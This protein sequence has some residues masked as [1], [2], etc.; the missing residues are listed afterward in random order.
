MDPLYVQCLIYTVLF[1]YTVPLLYIAVL[2]STLLYCGPLVKCCFCTMSLKYMAHFVQCSFC[3]MSYVYCRFYNTL[4]V[5]S[6]VPFLGSAPFVLRTLLFIAPLSSSASAQKFFSTV[7]F[8]PQTVLHYAPYLHCLFSTEPLCTQFPS[9]T[10]PFL[11]SATS[12]Q[13]TLCTES[14]LYIAPSA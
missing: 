9:C 13:C 1:L 11:Y 7:P 4:S 3:L 10:V 5:Q 12:V 8:G 2:Y 14:L 6:P